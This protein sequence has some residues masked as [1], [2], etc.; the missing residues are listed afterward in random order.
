MFDR[1]HEG[2]SN[3][4]SEI[5]SFKKIGCVLELNGMFNSEVEE[6]LHLKFDSNK[7]LLNMTTPINHI[8]LFR[9]IIDYH[10]NNK[11]NSNFMKPLQQKTHFPVT[12]DALR[13]FQF[14]T[15]LKANNNSVGFPLSTIIQ[16]GNKENEVQT[17]GFNLKKRCQ[18]S[19]HPS[20][21][22]K[23]KLSENE[24][25]SKIT[26]EVI[27]NNDDIESKLD[28]QDLNI[29]S[30]TSFW[31]PALGLPIADKH[32]ILSSETLP[33]IVMNAA[34]KKLNDLIVPYSV[35]GHNYFIQEIR[36]RSSQY[37]PCYKKSSG[38]FYKF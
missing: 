11:K 35:Q 27:G 5:E 21:I 25:Y 22:K 14:E 15:S 18:I 13:R 31:I 37:L 23:V 26:N 3:T 10:N 8:Y 4:S 17:V 36:V 29:F 38:K 6:Q 24:S 7:K 12:F 20:T 19:L 9:S 28:L 16:D 30:Q 33:D 34:I 32:L 1:F 2:N